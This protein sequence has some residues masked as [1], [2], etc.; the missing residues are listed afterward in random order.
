M[1]KGRGWSFGDAGSD[2]IILY[3]GLGFL[4]YIVL[5]AGKGLTQGLQ[6]LGQAIGGMGQG[7]G[8]LGSAAGNVA[9]TLGNA[10]NG[11]T[12]NGKSIWD[13]F[14]PTGSM[15]PMLQ[16]IKSRGGVIPALSG[17]QPQDQFVGPPAPDWAGPNVTRP[18]PTQSV[19]PDLDASVVT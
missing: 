17:S 1:A 18:D 2:K 15:D 11:A 14:F 13:S 7:V 4:A 12:E 19:Y 10:I 8:S 16:D 5:S 6:G 3:A 9:G